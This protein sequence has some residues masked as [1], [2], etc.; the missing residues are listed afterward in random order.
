MNAE[1]Q[2]LFDDRP[3]SH[4]CSSNKSDDVV[5]HCFELARPLEPIVDK[6]VAISQR[7][8]NDLFRKYWKNQKQQHKGVILKFNDIVQIWECALEKCITFL[9]SLRDRTISLSSVDSL[10]ANKTRGNL[11]QDV[12]SLEAGVCECTKS[13][14]PSGVWIEG[15]VSRM[16]Q[17]QSLFLHA[18]AASAFLALKTSL[19]LTGDFSMVERLAEQVSVIFLRLSAI[20]IVFLVYYFC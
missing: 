12:R 5:I 16:Y 2:Q 14:L 3:L 6:F 17:Y 18:S 15:C 19:G 20:F 1:L 13:P 10:L 11:S 9:E 7:H 4:I 8:A